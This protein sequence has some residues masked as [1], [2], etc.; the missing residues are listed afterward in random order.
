[1]RLAAALTSGWQ[2]DPDAEFAATRLHARANAAGDDYAAV[3]QKALNTAPADTHILGLDRLFRRHTDG[4][5]P[6]KTFVGAL[7]ALPGDENRKSLICQIDVFAYGFLKGAKNLDLLLP[8]DERAN[9]AFRETLAKWSN[10]LAALE[11][12][13][14][15]GKPLPANGGVSAEQ[16]LALRE[17]VSRRSA[18]DERRVLATLLVSGPSTT[19]QIKTDLGLNYSLGQRTLAVLED[20]EVIERRAGDSPAGSVFAITES[21]LPLTVFGLRET[22]GLDL[23]SALPTEH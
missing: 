12:F 2:D 17:I 15:L 13:E 19:D 11:Q 23:L 6:I 4:F 8:L 22:L 20:I 18:S 5:Q 10:T 21:A 9:I 3:L 14:R 7:A 16:Y 1:M